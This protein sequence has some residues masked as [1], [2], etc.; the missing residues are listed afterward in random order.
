[1]SPLALTKDNFSKVLTVVDTSIT[2]SASIFAVHAQSSSET[3]FLSG[4]DIVAYLTTLQSGDTKLQEIDFGTLKA[5]GAPAAAAQS[6]KPA[7]EKES[8]KIE[9]AVQIAVGV[10][11]EVDFAAW[12]TN[13]HRYH[14]GV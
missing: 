7:K 14:F 6:S 2:S 3:I 10:K 12:Y 9:G 4:K 1:M 5:E 13:V 8:A 11:K